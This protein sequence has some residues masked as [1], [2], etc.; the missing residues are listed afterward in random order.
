MLHP[1]SRTLTGAAAVFSSIG[2]IIFLPFNALT[3]GWGAFQSHRAH[4]FYKEYERQGKTFQ[5]LTR[6]VY[7]SPDKITQMILDDRV[8]L[9]IE[10]ETA[11]KKTGVDPLLRSRYASLD[12]SRKAALLNTV[13][14]GLFSKEYPELLAMKEFYFPQLDQKT[15]N[16]LDLPTVI[17]LLINV[18]KLQLKNEGIL[19]QALGSDCLDKIKRAATRGLE[20][21]MASSHPDVKEAA[22][23]ERATL[24]AEVDTN[25]VHNQKLYKTLAILGAI[26]LV[27]G[28]AAFLAT[29]HIGLIV[30][31]VLC[32]AYALSWVIFDVYSQSPT[33][34]TGKPGRYD[35][36]FLGLRIAVTILGIVLA[37]GA[38]SVLTG[39]VPLI[40][41]LAFSLA[42][43]AV[44]LGIYIHTLY[45]LKK[46]QRK[47]KEDHP[48]VQTLS[49]RLVRLKNRRANRDR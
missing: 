25:Y 38:I 23:A 35:K 13:L 42:L 40:L 3:V 39:G 37:I 33:A 12:G 21:R 14:S 43:G 18:R 29:G 1:A 5:A 10:G 8:G 32:F 24:L 4:Q 31:A 11:L 49:Q 28:I 7:V 17:G 15:V 2:N 26:G 30:M 27:L 48:E 16:S 19:S 6:S 46:Q 47:W 41:G 34:F 36:L 44:M 22:L 9:R 45:K 20:A